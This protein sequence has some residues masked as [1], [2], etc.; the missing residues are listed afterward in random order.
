MQLIVASVG[1]AVGV[2]LVHAVRLS[3]A[4]ELTSKLI[5]ADAADPV[6]GV[7]VTEPVTLPAAVPLVTVTMPQL[8]PAAQPPVGP[9]TVAPTIA[10]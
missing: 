7:A 4:G 9:A 10:L 6:L 2:I 8:A 5:A 3:P 1:A